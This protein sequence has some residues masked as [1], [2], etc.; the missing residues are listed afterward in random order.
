MYRK[1]LMRA[2]LMGALVVSMATSNVAPVMAAGDASA[3]E[4]QAKQS[5][6]V[7]MKVQFVNAEGIS[8]G[9][10]DY[11]LPE[12]VQNYSVLD[13]YVPDGYKMTES[14]D[15]TVEENGTIKVKVEKVQK[16][17]IMKVQFVD[18]DGDFISGGDYFLPEGV[19]NYSV[20]DEYS[21]ELFRP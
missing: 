19:Q 10:G 1:K 11:F 17:V 5:K 9:G 4:T 14:G 18:A 20:L 15:F 16:D 8:V 3:A 13:E 2:C 7:I 21:T 12:G 6:T